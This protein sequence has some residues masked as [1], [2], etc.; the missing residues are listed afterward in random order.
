[1]FVNRETGSVVVS[2][3][4]ELVFAVLRDRF[5]PDALLETEGDDRL[6]MVRGG[7]RATFVLRAVPGGT[8]VVGSRAQRPGLK[9][10]L[11]GPDQLR[12]AVQADLFRI[13][14]LTETL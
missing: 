6:E 11:G 10:F 1:M 8:Q 5:D 4:R 3:E 7:E 2:A 12:V 14:R 13:R 9:S